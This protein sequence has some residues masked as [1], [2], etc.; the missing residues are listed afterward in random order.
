[1]GS[2][3]LSYEKRLSDEQKER[4][5]N[6][7][8]N[9]F[10]SISELCAKYDVKSKSYICKLLGDNIRTQS[11][12]STVA[13]SKFPHRYK[14]SDITKNKIRNAR[15]KYISEHPENTAWRNYSESY[16]EKLFIKYLIN[17]GYDKKQLICRE[18]SFGKYRIDFAFVDIKVAVEIDGSQHRLKHRKEIDNAKDKLLAQSGWRVVRI[19]E[20]VVKKGEEE[21]DANLCDLISSNDEIFGPFGIIRIKKIQH[22]VQRDENRLSFRQKL[23]SISQRKVANR[24]TKEELFDMLKTLSFVEVGRMYNVSDNSVRKWCKNYGIPHRKCEYIIE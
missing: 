1:M 17:K 10:L 14:H 4:I 24:P 20:D 3:I 9:N 5:I 12:A 22:K 21:I 16:P 2:K 15:I 7:Y 19:G 6:D 13:H 23:N 8:V 11:K 18:F